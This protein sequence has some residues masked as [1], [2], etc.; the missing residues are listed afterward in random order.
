MSTSPEESESS[1]FPTD[2]LAD[3]RKAR[4]LPPSTAG[5]RVRARVVLADDNADMRESVRRLLASDY[6]VIRR[7]RWAGGLTGDL[8]AQTGRGA[9]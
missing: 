4:A 1:S 2:R 3:T 6:D 5:D 7:R 9:H 8:R